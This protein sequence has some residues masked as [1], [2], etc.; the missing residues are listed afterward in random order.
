MHAEFGQ[1]G[2]Y[3]VHLSPASGDK[4]TCELITAK[5]PVDIYMRNFIHA[6]TDIRMLINRLWASTLQSSIPN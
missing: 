4:V 2:V 6:I 3:D 1:F 5:E